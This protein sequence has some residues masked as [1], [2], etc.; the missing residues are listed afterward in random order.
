[1]KTATLDSENVK[2]SETNPALPGLLS[3]EEANAALCCS[4]APR[5]IDVREPD[6]FA[7]ER[8]DGSENMPLSSFDPES[9]SGS[10]DLLLLYC[11]GGARSADAARRLAAAG[12]QVQQI[13]GGIEGWK[14][15]QF[16]TLRVKGRTTISIMRQVQITV[17]AFGLIGFALAW[18][19][20]PLFLI[21]PA[22]FCA[23]LLFAGITGWCGLA[24]ALGYMPWNNAGATA[25]TPPA[26]C[27]ASSGETKK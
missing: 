2:T 14:S 23:G 26:T 21:I 6:E 10:T 18:L 7:A 8:I 13:E 9:L 24:L 22:F 12:C 11:R 16:P 4:S 19:V 5:L 17:G 15:A 3:P 25:T 27:C 20:S 1:M